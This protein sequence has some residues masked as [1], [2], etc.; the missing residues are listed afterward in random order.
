MNHSAV[1]KSN[2]TTGKRIENTDGDSYGIKIFPFPLIPRIS[3]ARALVKH[4]IG[5]IQILEDQSVGYLCLTVLA[6]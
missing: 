3:S 1:E 5:T 2:I 4:G 6:R